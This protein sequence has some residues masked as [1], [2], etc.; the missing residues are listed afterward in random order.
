MNREHLKDIVEEKLAAVEIVDIH[1]HLFPAS[2]EGMLLW[3][4]DEIL[5]YHY[6]IAEYFRYSEMEYADFFRLPKSRQ[7]D[8]VWNTLFLERSP[9]AKPSG[10]YSPSSR[11]WGLM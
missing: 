3:G 4:I 1:T 8:L 2:F 7:A 6:L 9:V 11:G 10:E 5:T